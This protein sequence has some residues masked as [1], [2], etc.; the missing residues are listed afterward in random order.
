M[1][2]TRRSSRTAWIWKLI[3]GN[4]VHVFLHLCRLSCSINSHLS[5]WT[6]HCL[7][8]SGISL[9]LFPWAHSDV[10]S[11]ILVC[12]IDSLW[13]YYSPRSRFYL[14]SYPLWLCVMFFILSLM[15][16]GN[17]EAR[18][19]FACQNVCGSEQIDTSFFKCRKLMCLRSSIQLGCGRLWGTQ[20]TN[21]LIVTVT[22]H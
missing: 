14:A 21:D 9:F 20:A 2:L 19:D 10:S 18:A 5:L 11:V 15:L 4:D 8:H 12:L 6:N 16:W 13:W 22:L 1:I 7:L 17:K 3:W